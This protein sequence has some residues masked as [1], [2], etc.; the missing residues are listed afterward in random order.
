M[1]VGHNKYNK[2]TRVNDLT[3]KGSKKWICRMDRNLPDNG[4]N[5]LLKEYV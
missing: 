4:K 1:T 2:S 5:F 3:Q